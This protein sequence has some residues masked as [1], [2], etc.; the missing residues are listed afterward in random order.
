MKKILLFV[1]SRAFLS[2]S[3]NVQLPKIFGDHMVLQRDRAITVWGWADPKERI[4]VTF[5]KQSK[6]ASAGKDGSWKIQLSAEAAGGPYTLTI[7]GKN[8]LS[9]TD[10]LVGD[11]W[12][13]SGQSNMEWTVRNSNNPQ[14]EIEAANFPTI[15]HFK[16]PNTVASE[17]QSDI[18]GGE[19]KPATSE[20]VADFTAVGYFFAR[21]L[22]K[23]LNVPIGLIN[24][25]WGGTHSETWTSREAFAADDEFKSMI[26]GMPRLN[27]DSL[28]KQKEIETRAKI[29]S[30]Q[31]KLDAPGASS[32]WID[33]SFD[34]SSWKTMTLPN[35]W[36]GLGLP[37]FDGVVWFRKELWLS[38]GESG[39]P[40]VLQL[41]MIDD[42]D[43]TFINGNKIGSTMQYNEPRKYLVPASLLKEGKNVITVRVED[44]GG[45]GGIYGDASKMILHVGGK[46]I[47]IAGD[48]RFRIERVAKGTASVGPNSYPTLLFNAMINPILPMSIKGALWYQGESNA[49]RA[50]QYRK[51]FPLMIKDWRQRWGQGDFPFYFVQLATFQANNG[52]SEVGSNWA[53]LREAQTMTLSLP[54]T[55]MAVTTDIGDPGDIHPRNKQDVGKR[56]AAI[57]LN[58]TYGRPRVD[59]GPTFTSMTI[60][61][62][63]A[64]LSFDNIGGGLVAKDKYGYLKGFEI[65]GEDRKFRFA[66]AMIEGDRVVVYH[67]KVSKPVAVRFGWADDAT[68]NNLFNAAGFPAVPFRTDNWKGIT[69]QAKFTFK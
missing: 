52:N 20:N 51:A 5:N 21:E 50:Y 56:L 14:E 2:T 26:A 1:L 48:W 39:K 37:D 69:E 4:T 53:E 36:E 42:W 32:K 3:A 30:L 22:T 33:A 12:I 65:A 13:C 35:L 8:T 64:I 10:V 24:T 58:R 9:L 47:S 59:S 54:N 55:G 11:V 25:S 45:G 40:A 7:K 49:G 17:P 41:A 19:W 16:I 15:R 68:D 66:K 29:E 46:S 28:A 23:E 63:K 38:P 18:R 61:G 43:E 27:L 31:G 62:S 6:T 44:T 34:D 67:D 57:A 60:E